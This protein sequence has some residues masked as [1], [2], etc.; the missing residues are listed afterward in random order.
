VRHIVVVGG[1]IAG[2]AA[3][4]RIQSRAAT[5]PIPVACTLIED[6]PRL[7]G[8]ITTRRRNGFVLEGGPDSFLSQKPWALDLCRELG[9]V[10]RLIGTRETRARTSVLVGDRLVPL[11]DG[12]VLGVPVQ[13]GPFLR[14]PLISWPGKLRMALDLVIPPRRRRGDESLADFIRRRLGAEALEKIAEPLMAGIHVADPEHLSIEATF[15]RLADLERLHGSLIRGLRRQSGA[16]RA[17][18]QASSPFL[19]FQTGM[20]ELVD[21][22]AGRLNLVR[23]ITGHRAVRVTWSDAGSPPDRQGGGLSYQIVL[24]DGSTVQADA[25]VLATPAYISA[26]LVATVNPPLASSLSQ[27]RYV[28]TAT[29]SL[30][31]RQTDVGHPLDGFGF[32]VPRREGRRISACTCSSAKFD[33]RAPENY[34]LIRAFVGGARDEAIVDLDDEALIRAVRMDVEDILGIT[35][36]PVITELFRWR[37]GIP[38][39][40]VD[41]LERV[42][43]LEER[44]TPG[45]FLA[46]AAY[47]GVGVPDC[48]HSGLDAAEKALQFVAAIQ[49]RGRERVA[50]TDGRS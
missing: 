39:Y 2:L 46:G 14:S 16:G 21:A 22:L 24:D 35:G 47:R 30:G 9:L 32:V 26:E 31:Y 25:V 43:V 19:S 42:A 48:V 27:I 12:A 17:A 29:V 18:R 44:C 3:A 10:E 28:S 49:T 34:R 41:H 20:Q 33:G 15:P 8:K 40:D 50:S 6:S 37:R 7:G 36:E 13:L 4:Y 5:S 1:G 45:L 38:Q 23:L 11:P